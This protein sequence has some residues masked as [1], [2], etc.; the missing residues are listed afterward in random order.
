MRFKFVPILLLTAATV[1]QITTTSCIIRVDWDENPKNVKK[2][3][4]PDAFPR[5][6]DANL[7]QYERDKQNR[8]NKKSELHSNSGGMELVHQGETSRSFEKLCTQLLSKCQANCME[9]WYPYTSIFVPT[10]AYRYAK[11]L[12]CMDRC[13]QFCNVPMPSRILSGETRTTPT[14]PAPQSYY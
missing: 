13:N 14:I 1:L 6:E 8:E 11:Q 9:E 2:T 10:I 4:S 5:A 7:T 12:Q 3:V